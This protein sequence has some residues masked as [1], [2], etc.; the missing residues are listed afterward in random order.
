[1]S[2]RG[3]W[4]RRLAIAAGCL[5]LTLMFAVAQFP[6][7]RLAPWLVGRI[8]QATGTRME[9]ARLEGSWS[10]TG[11]AAVLHGLVVHV[12]GR[13][14]LAFERL[15]V[16]PALST[17][18]LAGE[19]ALGVEL[20]LAGGSVVGTV[21]PVGEAGF[22]GRFDGI[23]T[24]ALP[25]ALAPDGLPVDGVL[26]G[27]SDVRRQGHLWVGEVSVKGNDGSLALP[28]LP[29]A[30]PYDTLLAELRLGEDGQVALDQGSLQGPL[31]SFEAAGSLALDGA[32]RPGALDLTVLMR[33]VDP[34]LRGMLEQ[35]GFRLDAG[36]G[37]EIAVGGTVAAPQIQLR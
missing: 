36:G 16:R 1:M 18:W 26:S 23:D 17:S 19:P 35:Q 9:L 12:P 27:A 13:G 31:A 34:S 11:P 10:A 22:D 3:G 7:E 8:E 33:D 20:A 6:W 15:R 5:V 28:S 4:L 2:P 37:A 21:W 30:L 32:G 24:A 25:E 29:I 14:P